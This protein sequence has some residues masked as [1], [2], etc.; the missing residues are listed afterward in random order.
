MKTSKMKTSNQSPIPPNFHLAIRPVAAALFTLFSIST[1]AHAHDKIVD[2]VVIEKKKLSDKILLRDEIVATE[3]LSARELEK[4]GATMLTEA[5]D[6]RPGI[7]MQLECSICNVRNIVLNNLPGRYTTLLI[8]GIPIYSAVSSAYGLDSVSLGGIERI[9]IARGAGASLIAPEALSG[10]VNIVTRRPTENEFIASQQ[11]GS[12]GQAQ[13]ALFG[14]TAFSGGAL[15]AYFNHDQHKT[16]D[17]D[18]NGVSEYS[19]FQRKL[20]GIGYFLDDVGGFK[21][22]GRLD[23]VNEK[24]NGGPVG[25]DY[26]SIKMNT[27]GNPFNWAKGTH[28]SPDARAWVTPDGSGAD[29]LANGQIGQFYNDGRAGMAEII[30]TDRTQFVS[31]ATR[32]LGDG[33]LRFAMGYA[34]HK[35]DSFYET[36]TY[37]ASQTQYYLEASTQ[38]PIGDTLVSAGINY[39]FENLRSK[40]ASG[41]ITNDGIDNY[42]YRTPAL[43]LQAYRSFADGQVEANGSVRVDQNNV[44]GAIVSPRFNVSWNHDQ[45]LNSRFAIGKGFRAPTSFFEQD[46]GILDTTRIDRQISKP[47]VS[48]NATYTLSYSA[49]RLSMSGGLNWNRIYNMALLDPSQTDAVTGDAITLFTSSPTPITVVGADFS[50]NYEITPALNG[51]LGLERTRYTFAPGTLTFA[52]PDRRAYFSLDYESGPWDVIARATWTGKQDLA[53][54]YDYANNPR[55][56]LDGS[57]KPERSPQFWTVDLRAEYRINK[58]WL[59]YANVDNLFNYQQSNK[60]SLLWLDR[61]GGIDV[62]HIWGPNRGRAIYA[63]VKFSM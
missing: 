17:G 43:F 38:Q 61:S 59:I 35:Q 2:T 22:R 63:G 3:S 58:Q 60:D 53:K 54:F 13:T 52:R 48:H 36:A 29:T 55:Y 19:G 41:G 45:Q 31:S 15:T 20:G 34:K 47:E 1:I 62:T 21:L 46:H 12:F 5:L 56:N 57:A 32:R 10:V 18:G 25:K 4:T 16:V 28:A 51:K 44:F 8:D 23:F 50:I 27:T 49:D 40:G 14:A 9:D 30:F 6:K 39:R 24:R 42:E 37:I 26:A 11:I 33:S 7:A